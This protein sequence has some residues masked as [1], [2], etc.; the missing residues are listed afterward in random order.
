MSTRCAKSRT[1]SV[2][3]ADSQ[4]ST[5][6]PE[7]GFH[8]LFVANPVPMWV[9]DVETLAFL[10]VNEAAVASY[11]YSE[12]E[13]LAM[14]IKDIRPPEDIPSLLMNVV[15]G[16]G[17]GSPRPDTW[18]HRTKD[19]QVLDVEITAGRIEFDGRRAALVL[20]HDVSE[21]MQLQRRLRGALLGDVDGKAEPRVAPL[22][23]ERMGGDLH[24]DEATVLGHMSPPP[25][26]TGELGS[27]GDVVEQ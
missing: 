2:I 10:A 24:L 9:Y 4:P 11:G 18:R 1:L 3:T 25:R 22:E 21:K 20:A 17:F 8:E 12:D 13:F 7:P 14:T 15:G 16:D 26:G 19:G 5:A 23:P 6:H 27:D